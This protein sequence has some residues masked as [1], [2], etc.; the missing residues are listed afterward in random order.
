MGARV[1]VCVAVVVIVGVAVVVV[2]G[3]VCASYMQLHKFK[4][5]QLDMTSVVKGQKGMTKVTDWGHRVQSGYHVGKVTAGNK[6][7]NH[8]CNK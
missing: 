6:H 4:G 5:Q 2:G 8:T 1:C 7:K 3:V